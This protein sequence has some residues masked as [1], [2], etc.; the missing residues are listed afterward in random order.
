[1]YASVHT[2]R[3]G[4][5][6][7]SDDHTA[8]G[9]DGT[10][11]TPFGEAIPLPPGAEV[12]PIERDA[13]GFGRD[14]HPRT[15]AKGRLALAA[16]LP[17]G[18][19]RCLF[20][21]YRDDRS[22][23]PLELVPYAAVAATERGDLVVAAS[24]TDGGIDLDAASA[25]GGVPAVR[26]HPANALARQLA[27]CA[28]ENACRD[29]GAGVGRGML[30][31]PLGAPAAERPRLP[32]ALRSGYAG[33]PTERAAFR[34]EPADILAVA[35]DHL[36]RGGRGI[37]FGRACDGEPLSLLRVVEE[38]VTELRRR[39]PAAAV[40]LETSGSDPSA[41]RRALDAGVDAVTVRI[42]SARPD[43]YETLH[44]PVAHRWSDVRTS[45]QLA[46]ARR[47]ALT[48]AL[49]VLPGLTDRPDEIDAIV[50]LLGELAGGRIELRD[51]GCDPLRA[52]GAF[53]SVRAS[54]MGH[55]LA[56]IAEA[57]HFRLADAPAAAG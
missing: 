27:R 10:E 32:V 42:G 20:P 57:D 51:L 30:P 37:S 43:T 55:L 25:S 56:R 53:P 35:V 3:S 13:V 16:V 45:L 12:V 18:Y 52:V 1:M 46:A 34:P 9:M 39:A 6:F 14:G 23:A 41:L 8:A 24:R 47:V 29:A 49:L 5:V 15:L 17:S 36:A 31:V 2:D 40:H 7:V 26:T 19:V 22:K 48:V 11:A 44:G 54:G 38:S 33:D 28:R 50:E 4:R 21:A